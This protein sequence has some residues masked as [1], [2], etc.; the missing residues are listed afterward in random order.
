MLVHLALVAGLCSQGHAQART[1]QRSSSTTRAEVMAQVLRATA[2]FRQTVF[3]D[4]AGVDECSIRAIVGDST[5]VAKTFERFVSQPGLLATRADGC[6]VAS[7][8]AP[9]AQLA[10]RLVL[11]D[12]ATLFGDSATVHLTVRHGEHVHRERYLLRRPPVET[13]AWQGASV[14]IFGILRRQSRR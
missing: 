7:A 12:S 11:A 9:D 1:A 8:N 2:S 14:E 4:G 5:T 10:A 6:A 13:A 3:A